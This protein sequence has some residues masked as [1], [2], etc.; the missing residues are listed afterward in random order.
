M[1]PILVYES[2]ISLFN[3]YHDGRVQQGMSYNK[4]LYRLLKTYEL[5]KRLQAYS[6]GISLSQQHRGI[7]ITVSHRHYKV[8][9]ELRSQMAEEPPRLTDGNSALS[10]TVSTPDRQSSG[11]DF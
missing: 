1:L 11:C 8:W 2:F 4:S 7:V 6:L 3:F 10:S 5:N 9:L